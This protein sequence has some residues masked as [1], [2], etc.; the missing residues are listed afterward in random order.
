[1]RVDVIPDM[2]VTSI[3]ILVHL[4]AVLNVVA[5][6]LSTSAWHASFRALLAENEST[7]TTML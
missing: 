1:M 6:S 4:A 2:M 3:A 5:D 7:K